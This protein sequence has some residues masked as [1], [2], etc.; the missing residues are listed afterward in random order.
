LR[1]AVVEEEEEAYDLRN[2]RIFFNF[3]IIR[4]MGLFNLRKLE[5]WKGRKTT[6]LVV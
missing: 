3:F 6:E 2:V 1:R 5:Y 4:N